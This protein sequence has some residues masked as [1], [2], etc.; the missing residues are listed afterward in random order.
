MRRFG[1]HG[2]VALAGLVACGR[3]GSANDDAPDPDPKPDASTT[4]F[5]PDG[6]GVVADL[7]AAIADGGTK[8]GF[9]AKHTD[10]TLC[11]DFDDDAPKAVAPLGDP[12]FAWAI[13]GSPDG[14][15]ALRVT[16]GKPAKDHSWNIEQGAFHLDLPAIPTTAQLDFEVM[17]EASRVDF[18]RLAGFGY[19]FAASARFPLALDLFGNAKLYAADDKGEGATAPMV[20]N[21]WSHVSMAVTRVDDDLTGT[22]TVD[23][24]PVGPAKMSVKEKDGHVVFGFGAYDISSTNTDDLVVW[25]DDL[26][27][28]AK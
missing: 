2:V 28:T 21:R 6:G 15:R 22:I 8:S 13:G 20:L 12:V 4:A 5:P 23:D 18:V 7:D 11:V 16:A 3:F 17:C 9:C 25:F 10:A 1:I 24:K 14:R 19:E 27:L 26:V